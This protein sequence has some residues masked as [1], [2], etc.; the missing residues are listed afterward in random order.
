[1]VSNSFLNSRSVQRGISELVSLEKG[2]ISIII[3]TYN[4]SARALGDAEKS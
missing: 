1:M 4:H 3:P 2:T